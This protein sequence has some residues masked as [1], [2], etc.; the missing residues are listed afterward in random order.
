MSDAESIE[1]G[2][3]E[4]MPGLEASWRSLEVA[5]IVI[6]LLG[7]LGILFPYVTGIS[8][9]LLLGGVL[10]VGALIHVAHAFRARGWKGFA[11]QAILA[12]VYAFAGISLLANPVLGLATLTI[13]LIAYFLVSGIVETVMGLQLRGE[14]SWGWVVASG[15]LSIVLAGLLWA[16]FPST[17]AWAVGLLFGISLLSTGISMYSV[18]RSAKKQYAAGEARTMGA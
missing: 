15:V 18:G 13:L 6:A 8:I 11:W 17:A 10:V 7:V 16:G 5:G 9:S 1:S 3:M 12:I 4:T 14:P 2:T